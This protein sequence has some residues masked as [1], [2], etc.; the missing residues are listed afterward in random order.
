MRLAAGASRS[1]TCWAARSATC[2]WARS[3]AG[4][5][6]TTRAAEKP[7]V[8]KLRAA[9]TTSGALAATAGR[10]AAATW[11]TTRRSA[12]AG[13]TP[14][15]RSWGV[16]P[17][18]RAAPATSPVEVAAMAAERVRRVPAVA[19]RVGRRWRPRVRW[20]TGCPPVPAG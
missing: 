18:L 19:S 1:A 17:E 3:A 4:A 2:S 11:S 9:S 14:V 10:S 20:V 15:E 12:S 8:P 16:A 5:A 7:V 13:A 6:V